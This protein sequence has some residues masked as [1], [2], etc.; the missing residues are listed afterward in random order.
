MVLITIFLIFYTAGLWHEAVRQSRINNNVAQSAKRSAEVASLAG[1]VAQ[2]A[3]TESRESDSI[4]HANFIVENRP[5][6]GIKS[7]VYGWDKEQNDTVIQIKVKNYGRLPAM[8][9]EIGIWPPRI[10]TPVPKWHFGFIGPQ[11][12][13]AIIPPLTTLSTNE[14][15]KITQAEWHEITAGAKRLYVGGLITYTDAFNRRDTTTFCFFLNSPHGS[16]WI[17]APKYNEMR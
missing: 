2:R 10:S 1:E 16:A 17:P 9:T 13:I 5:W 6:V 3:L 14:P 11:T 15:I 7:I 12:S 4:S 8:Q